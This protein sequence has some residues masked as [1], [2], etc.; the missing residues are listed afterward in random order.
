[1]KKGGFLLSWNNLNQLSFKYNCLFI[2]I[3]TK[4]YN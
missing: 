1:M 4:S 2:L 3:K